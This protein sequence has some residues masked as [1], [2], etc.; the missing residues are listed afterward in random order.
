MQKGK[1][2]TNRVVSLKYVHSH[3]RLPI[4]WVYLGHCKCPEHLTVG[5][6]SKH[7]FSPLEKWL[8]METKQIFEV[9]EGVA[10]RWR[11]SDR[12]WQDGHQLMLSI[13]AMVCVCVCGY[14]LNLVPVIALWIPSHIP[15]KWKIYMVLSNMSSS[16]LMLPS[17]ANAAGSPG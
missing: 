9:G 8:K 14:T 17:S 2:S 6:K 13:K 10:S 4:F 3:L 7:F 11:T 12:L 1:L 15:R 16:N 5:F